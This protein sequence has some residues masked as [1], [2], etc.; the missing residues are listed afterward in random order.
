MANQETEFSTN[1]DQTNDTMY[2][3]EPMLAV[4]FK[5]KQDNDT[6]ENSLQDMKT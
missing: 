5:E 2:N 1:A 6:D 3:L 4:S